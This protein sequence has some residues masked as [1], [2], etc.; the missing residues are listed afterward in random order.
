MQSAE[1]TIHTIYLAGP[2]VFYPDAVAIGQRKKALCAQYGFNGLF[3]LDNEV[4]GQ[5]K[6]ALA[7]SIYAGN[8]AFMNQADAIIA[9]ITPFRGP[10]MD[11]GT[12]FEIGYF[13]A[14]GKLVFLYSNHGQEYWERVDKNPSDKRLDKDGCLIEDFDLVENLMI[15]HASARPVAIPDKTLP[16]VSLEQFE[17]ILIEITLLNTAGGA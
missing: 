12:A 13:A 8:I 15:T 6:A 9:N 4:S 1:A 17:A 7:A 11:A 2:D 10:G 3:P 5:S 16:F 14:Q